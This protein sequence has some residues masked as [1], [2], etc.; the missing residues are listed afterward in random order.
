[1]ENRRRGIRQRISRLGPHDA[2]GVLKQFEDFGFHR[3]DQF[4]SSDDGQTAEPPDSERRFE[5]VSQ[6]W[7]R[8]RIDLFNQQTGAALLVFV[9]GCSK[10]AK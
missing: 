7:N 5:L 3:L 9:E 8:V 6:E 10:A 2:I 1:M 4:E